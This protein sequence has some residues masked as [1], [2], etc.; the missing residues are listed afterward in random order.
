MISLKKG[1]FVVIVFSSI[2]NLYSVYHKVG[3]Y[4]D[5]NNVTRIEIQDSIAYVLD[6]ED[7]LL[8][9]NVSNLLNTGLL[10]SP[11]C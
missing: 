1:L 7:G 2:L 10:G 8:L 6:Q 11:Y 3:G 9:V 4:F 5:S